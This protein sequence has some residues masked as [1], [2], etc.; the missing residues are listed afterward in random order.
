MANITAAQVYQEVLA[1]GGSV[2]QGQVAAALVS[3][4]E[5]NGDPTELAGGKG[6]AQGLFQFEPG[7]WT[8]GAG[9]GKNG[10]PSSVGAATWQQ[11]VTGFINDTGGP[12]GSDFQAWG[13]DLVAN[14]GDPNSASNPAYSYTGAPQPGSKVANIIAGLNLGPASPGSSAGAASPT[15]A[16]VAGSTAVTGTTAA[17]TPDSTDIGGMSF[18]GTEQQ[19]DALST[20]AANLQAYGF[21][22]AQLNGPQGLVNWA[23]GELTNNTDP[24]QI[25]LDLQNQPAFEQQFPGFKKA[26][27]ELANQGLQ[28]VSVSQYQQYQTQA[29]AM[30]Q[31]AGL[32]PGFLNSNN[33]GVLIGGNVSSSELSARLNDATSLAI[34]STPA[35]RAEFNAYFGVQTD[36]ALEPPP[37]SGGFIG[38][39]TTAAGGLSNGQIA[40]IALDPNVAEPIIKQQIQAAQIGGAGVTS[41]TGAIDKATAMQLAQA[42]ITT[43]QATSAFQNTAVYA[44]LES[45]RPGMGAEASE[46]TVTAD[47][48]ATGALLGNPGAQRQLQT[49]E[50]TAKAPFAGGGGFVQNTAGAVGAG[51]SKSTGAGQ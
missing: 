17:N 37:G 14:S 28:A 3:G 32:P 50:E 19:T 49:A 24:T 6:P 42:G 51:S 43:S 9:G 11:Q 44:P 30:A 33:I 5:S 40:A 38:K 16:N 22:P 31:A 18:N 4:I 7:T 1:Q 39:A 29:M 2:T 48:L 36:S 8:G 41:G 46:G 12:G 47:Q 27:E 13:P 26:N 21:T 10:L 35:A 20:L 15:G 23:W 25:A 45:V 34:N